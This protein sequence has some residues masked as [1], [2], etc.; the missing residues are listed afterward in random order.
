[1]SPA[2]P[3]S[4]GTNSWAAHDLQVV[5]DCPVCGR[6]AGRQLWHADLIDTDFAAPGAWSLY[7]CRG[8]GSGWLD[9]RPNATSLPRA[10]AGY[11]THDEIRESVIVRRRGFVRRWLHDAVN[12]YMNHRYGTRHAPTSPYGKWFIWLLPPLRAAADSTCRHLPSAPFGGG[13]LLDVGCG[14][15]AFLRLARQM[16]W[17]ATGLDFDPKAVEQ[18][19]IAG[20]DVIVGGLDVLDA[21][22]NRY[23]VIT[24]SHVI[25]HVQNPNET[26]AR[27][28]RLLKPGGMLW[29]ETPNLASVGHQHYGR[30]WRGLEPPRHL[31]LFNVRSLSAALS[32]AGF[33]DVAQRWHAL[34]TFYVLRASRTNRLGREARPRLIWEMIVEGVEALLPARREF[35][36]FTAV[37][38]ALI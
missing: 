13:Q 14:N 10:Y 18:A 24:M 26:L 9:P 6:G 1:M 16:G 38:P 30:Y 2:K 17:N 5:P 11:H 15:G 37:K 21:E 31:V 12:G 8:C 23:D 20:L 7:R 29:I 22:S 3:A 19:R 36:T 4:T 34:V 35:L 27:L 32:S 33:V 28:Y 25:E